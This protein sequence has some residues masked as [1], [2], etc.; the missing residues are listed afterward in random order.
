MPDCWYAVVSTKENTKLSFQTD[1]FVSKILSKKNF[2]NRMKKRFKSK[3]DFS[4]QMHLLGDQLILTKEVKN[5]IIIQ[6]TLS[7]IDNMPSSK[8]KKELLDKTIYSI[9]S[10][11]S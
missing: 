9:S 6:E 8:E 11:L 3:K 7:I 10:N 1:L 2:M 4:K 5:S